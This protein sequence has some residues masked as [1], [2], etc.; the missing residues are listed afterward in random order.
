MSDKTYP[1]GASISGRPV[2]PL[3]ITE[4]LKK[5]RTNAEI[6]MELELSDEANELIE[7]FR[8]RFAD[9]LL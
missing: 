3:D 5:N 2:A 4:L 8:T 6:M 7:Y 1:F 9:G